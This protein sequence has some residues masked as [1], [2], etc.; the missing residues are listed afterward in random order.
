LRVNNLLLSKSIKKMYAITGITGHVA[1]VIGNLLLEK[2]VPVRAVVRNME[3]GEAW[4]MKGAEPAIAE[5]HD[6]EALQRAFTGCEG[7]FVMTPTLFNSLDPMVEHDRMLDAL[8]SAL[9]EAQPKK[10]VFLSSVGA[11]HPSGTGAIKK[12]HHMEQ[13]FS[14]LTMPNASIRAAWFMDNFQG[15]IG[16][17]RETGMLPSFLD[18]TTLTIPMVATKDIGA[19][20]AGLLT[21]NWSGRRIIE[22]EGPCRYSTK[23]VAFVL[24]YLAKKNVVAVPIPAEEYRQTYRSLGL[25]PSAASL[26]AEMNRG[27][28]AEYIGF[29]GNGC[30]H[31]EGITFLED[32]IR[33]YGYGQL[34]GRAIL[35]G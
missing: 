25:T 24:S 28:N 6:E 7:V 8:Y 18:P 23:D 11:Q 4:K 29:E 31:V 13:M 10:V 21:E 15:V 17:A 19:I 12:L 27:F 16:Y 33:S 32:A 30:E 22:L 26:M 34:N 3:K 14:R 2:R 1:G 35:K 20:A 5:L 9:Q